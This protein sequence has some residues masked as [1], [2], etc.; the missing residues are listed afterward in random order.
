MSESEAVKE[1][2][3]MLYYGQSITTA[4]MNT[5]LQRLDTQDLNIPKHLTAAVTKMPKSTQ[6]NSDEILA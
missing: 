6:A 1:H 4:Q 3:Q 5:K 2:C